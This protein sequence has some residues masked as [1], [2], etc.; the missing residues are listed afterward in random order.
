[1]ERSKNFFLMNGI[2]VDS[3]NGKTDL[4]IYFIG[5]AFEKMIEI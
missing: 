2:N 3:F 4:Q 1:M 5:L